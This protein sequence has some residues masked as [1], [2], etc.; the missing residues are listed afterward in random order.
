M[1]PSP[2][3]FINSVLKAFRIQKKHVVLYPKKE[4][5]FTFCGIAVGDERQ[6]WA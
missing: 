5:S 2:S 6:W 3:T 1:F 4:R